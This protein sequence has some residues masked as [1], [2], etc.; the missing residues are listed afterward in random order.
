MIAK[1]IIHGFKLWCIEI[2]KIEAYTVINHHL[3][4]RK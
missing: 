4:T 3:L 1:Y 2:K